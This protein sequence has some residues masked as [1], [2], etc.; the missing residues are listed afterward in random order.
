VH[1]DEARSIAACTRCHDQLAEPAAARR[2]A[3]TGHDR[4]SCLDCHMPRVVMGL[5]HFVRTH[6]ISS[7]TDPR[8]YADG[9]PNACNLCHLD[10]TLRWTLNALR[11]GWDVAL[12]PSGDLDEPAGA[13]WLASPRPALRILA[14]HAYARS[15]LARSALPELARGLT[16]RLPYV[17]AWTQL[18]I[19]SSTNV[20]RAATPEALRRTID[21]IKK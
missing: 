21:A 13:Q 8:L 20:E 6:R 16:D 19:A 17:R 5:D 3:G 1:A 18:A 2:H 14:A 11:D 9:S 12:S 15:P 10:R 7:P 4:A